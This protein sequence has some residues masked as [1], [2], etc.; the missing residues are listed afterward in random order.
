M[1]IVRSQNNVPVRLTAERW[2][3]IIAEHPEMDTQREQVLETV[4]APDMIQAGDFSE[5]LAIRFY[6]Q[7]PLTEKYLVVAYR[8]TA[9]DDGFI[10]TAYLTRRPSA[11]R[12]MIWKR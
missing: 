11:R 6:P 8:E 10:L 5:L 12:E 4:N 7:T 9:V 3:H 1:I 2:E